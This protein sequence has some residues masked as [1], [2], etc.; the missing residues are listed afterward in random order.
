MTI[1]LAI[2]GLCAYGLSTTGCIMDDN[3]DNTGNDT[4]ALLKSSKM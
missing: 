4:K 1:E 2:T 3:M